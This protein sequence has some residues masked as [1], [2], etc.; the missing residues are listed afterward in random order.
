MNNLKSAG[1]ESMTMR[2]RSLQKPLIKLQMF[3]I[4]NL[5]YKQAWHIAS[6]ILPRNVCHLKNWHQ[7]CPT[8]PKNF[9]SALNF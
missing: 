2:E 8:S 6:E 3:I 5:I 9:F 1:L 7:P 4:F